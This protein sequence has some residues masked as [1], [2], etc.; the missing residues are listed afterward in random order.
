MREQLA[1]LARL[2]LGWSLVILGIVGL[3]VPVLQGILFMLLGLW[4]LSI[5]SRWAHRCMFKLRLRFPKVH[6]QA[7]RLAEKFRGK[8][9][10]LSNL[11]SRK[12]G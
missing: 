5:D 6:G 10:K 3:F 12:I 1:R 7:Q 2:I 9:P 4:V 11:F 8:F